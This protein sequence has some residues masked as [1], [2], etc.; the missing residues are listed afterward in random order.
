[1]LSTRVIGIVIFVGIVMFAPE[2]KEWAISLNKRVTAHLGFVTMP[3]C[4]RQDFK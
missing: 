3:C 1:M 4:L 2:F